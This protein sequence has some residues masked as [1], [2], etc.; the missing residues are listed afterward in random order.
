M[1]AEMPEF[2]WY[3]GTTVAPRWFIIE[4]LW[5]HSRGGTDRPSN[6]ETAC[7]SCNSLKSYR[8]VPEYRRLLAA[9]R[10]VDVRDVC[11]AGE[12]VSGKPYEGNTCAFLV[13]S[14]H[15]FK[16]GPVDIWQDNAADG[17]L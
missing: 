16:H 13:A 14:W 15:W 4:H 11:F 6:L 3:C 5:P 7:R 8:T 17:L 1:T 12:I 9:R 10:R 2:C